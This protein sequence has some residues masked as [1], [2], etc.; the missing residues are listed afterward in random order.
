MTT[1]ETT[2]DVA[3]TG[4]ST[5]YLALALVWAVAILAAGW[6]VYAKAGVPGWLALIPI[7]NVFGLLQ[8]VRRPL[9]WFFLLLVPIVN[10]VVLVVVL[11]DLAKAFGRGLGMALVLL[12]LTPIG[13]LV[14]GFGSAEYQLDRELRTA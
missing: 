13:Y 4:G 1:L 2:T 14:L 12:F 11:W 6:K 10:L 3:A 9:W 8:V 7:V 5:V